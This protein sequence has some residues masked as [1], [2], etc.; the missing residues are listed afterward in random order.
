MITVRID[1]IGASTKQFEQYGRQDFGPLHFPWANY[2]FLKRMWPFKKWGPYA[3][4]TAQEWTAYLEIF[5]NFDIK[6]IVAIT[7]SW[8][9]KDS[10]L[11]PFPDK[12]PEEA[13][14]LKE[15]ALQGKITIA[16]HGLTH[17]IIGKHLPL[18][19]HSNRNFHREFWPELDQAIHTEHIQHSQEILEN[20]LD[21]PIEIFVPPGNVWSIKTYNALRNTN[22]KKVICGRYMLDSS[23][24]LTGIDFVDDLRDFTILHDRDLKLKNLPWIKAKLATLQHAS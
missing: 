10:R 24:P 6:P 20:W 15:A 21:Q 14:V 3:E 1:D 9:E 8:V 23:D 12:W 2:L 19:R 13:A 4:L 16:N 11:T 5:R 18:L 7:A 22:I 17:C